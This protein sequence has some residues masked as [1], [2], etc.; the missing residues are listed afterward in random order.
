MFEISLSSQM[1]PAFA[2]LGREPSTQIGAVRL[3]QQ[4]VRAKCYGW[5]I[6]WP[7][8]ALLVKHSALLSGT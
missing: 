8:L 1:N 5:H 2:D 3:S 7:C 6:H 4:L